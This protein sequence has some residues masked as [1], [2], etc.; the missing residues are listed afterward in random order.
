MCVKSD[1]RAMALTE[2][3]GVRGLLVYEDFCGYHIAEWGE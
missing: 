2:S 3:L 1:E